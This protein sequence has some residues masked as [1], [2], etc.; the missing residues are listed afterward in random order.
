M[1]AVNPA[2]TGVTYVA[3]SMELWNEKVEVIALDAIAYGSA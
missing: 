3:F 1:S 2:E